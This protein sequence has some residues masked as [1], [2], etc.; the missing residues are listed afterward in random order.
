MASAETTCASAPRR[1]PSYGTRVAPT[2]FFEVT[3]E[4]INYAYNFYTSAAVSAPA[5]GTASAPA[6]PAPAA[7]TSTWRS[8]PSASASGSTSCTATPSL[9]VQQAAT[10][11]YL[12]THTLD[13]APAKSA[14][15]Q[16]QKPPVTSSTLLPDDLLGVMI[17]GCTFSWSPGGVLMFSARRSSSAT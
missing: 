15:I 8:R 3:G 1:R 7:A 2:R 12:Q 14:T 10:P 4:D 9:P 13:T 5:V 6:P 17:A 11:A 16:V